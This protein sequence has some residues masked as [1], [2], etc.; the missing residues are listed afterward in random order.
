VAC[1]AVARE[2]SEG[3]W[4]CLDSNQEPDRYERPALTIELQARSGLAAVCCSRFSPSSKFEANFYLQNTSLATNIT[5]GRGS[6]HGVSISSIRKDTA[7][8]K[9]K[10]QR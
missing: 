1:Q 9:N 4:A 5:P 7:W 2:A 10:S 8:G 3:W 6:V